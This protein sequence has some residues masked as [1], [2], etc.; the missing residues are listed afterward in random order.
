MTDGMRRLS[1]RFSGPPECCGDLCQGIEG[2]GQTFGNEEVYGIRRPEA[3]ISIESAN[4]FKLAIRDLD[5]V[6]RVFQID[7]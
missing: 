6:E 4:G 3:E 2:T 7:S 5:P 1:S